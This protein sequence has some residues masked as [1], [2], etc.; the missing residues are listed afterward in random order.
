M[1]TGLSAGAAAYPRPGEA[2]LIGRPVLR[3]PPG[4]RPSEQVAG[5]LRTRVY[6]P[7]SLEQ[8]CF[9][10]GLRVVVVLLV[11][12]VTPDVAV[13]TG[14][15]DLPVRVPLHVHRPLPAAP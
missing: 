13:G 10:G 7:E 12:A 14:V 5:R 3:R 1:T 11:L 2:D 9:G 4:A 8:R 6:R 15:D